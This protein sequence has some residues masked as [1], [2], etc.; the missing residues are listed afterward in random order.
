M[1]HSLS[2][3]YAT[4]PQ[5]NGKLVMKT[6]L[7]DFDIELFSKQTPKACKNFIQLC[8]EGYYNNTQFH[9]VIKDFMAQGGDPTGTGQGGESVYGEGF[10]DEYQTRLKFNRRGLLGMANNGEKNS[11]GSQF[12]VTL[13]ACQWLNKKH[14]LFGKVT[15]DTIYNVVR[16]NDILVGDDERPNNPV[17]IKSIE[18]LTNPYPE[19]VPR[20]LAEP[21]TIEK[22]KK[23]KKKK[24]VKNKGLLAFGAESDEEVDLVPK[25]KIKPLHEVEGGFQDDMKP[26]D[27]KLR[28]KIFEKKVVRNDEE[29]S[30]AA[31]E[32]KMRHKVLQ[33]RQKVVKEEAKEPEKKPEDM[34]YDELKTALIKQRQES[35]KRKREAPSEEEETESVIEKLRKKYKR[36]KVEKKE[37]AK[38]IENRL[39]AFNTV[40]LTERKGKEEEV[41]K[42]LAI[43]IA[44][45]VKTGEE[46]EDSDSW[47]PNWFSK[48]ISF[49]KRPQDVKL[50]NL[51][52][53][54][55][56]DNTGKYGK[57]GK[58]PKKKDWKPE[59]YFK[60]GSERKVLNA[61]EDSGRNR[62]DERRRSPEDRGRNRRDERRKSPEDRRERRGN[63]RRR[64]RSRSRSLDRF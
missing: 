20:K 18:I 8:M 31:F 22:K 50:F 29:D 39:A 53:Y 12:F 25:K 62:R 5:T 1:Q 14:T 3:F 4:E 44:D 2:G 58:V 63:G 19:I 48:Q 26:K 59:V 54:E 46:S 6:T 17:L 16:F 60:V 35:R 45:V 37:H 15:G 21:I 7:G 38:E 55:I 32:R 51:A 47:D 56:Y 43:G 23:K 52:D 42:A 27:S 64:K 28:K 57:K 24:K 36:Q 40:V 9:R 61:P 13:G 33:S 10:K 30:A 49:A 41:T 11:N 34:D